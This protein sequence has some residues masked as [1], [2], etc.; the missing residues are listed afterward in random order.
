MAHLPEGFPDVSRSGVGKGWFPLVEQ[1]HKY[2]SHL[3][4]DYKIDQVKEKF[5]TLR[6]YYRCSPDLAPEKE[7]AMA[8]IV[9]FAEGVSARTCETCGNA[10]S[11]RCDRTWIVTLCDTCDSAKVA[12]LSG[13]L[14]DASADN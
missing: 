5:G 11:Y 6:Y 2:L 3:D 14:D 9:A 8:E 13:D 1:V 7:L 12:K 4:P 10:G